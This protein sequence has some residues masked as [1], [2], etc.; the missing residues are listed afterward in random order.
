MTKRKVGAELL[1]ILPSPYPGI[2][3]R[4]STFEVLRTKECTPTHFPSVVFTFGL[5]V[6]SIKEFRGASLMIF[7]LLSTNIDQNLYLMVPS[8]KN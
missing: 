6:E 1:V 2:L 8:K 5:A 4:P 3:A 7:G